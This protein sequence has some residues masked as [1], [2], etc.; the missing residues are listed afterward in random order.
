MESQRIDFNTRVEE[1][2]AKNEELKSY[3]QITNI[4]KDKLIIKI[5]ELEDQLKT[6]EVAKKYELDDQ[7]KKLQAKILDLQTTTN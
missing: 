6:V 7:A 2:T 3:N 5:T 1:L 4:E